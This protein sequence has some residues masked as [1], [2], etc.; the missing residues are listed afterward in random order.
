[1][2]NMLSKLLTNLNSPVFEDAAARAVPKA[3][4]GDRRWVPLSRW[5]P[6]GWRGQAEETAGER[7][8]PLCM[9]NDLARS[10]VTC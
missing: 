2:A 5:P 7:R 6:V 9:S 8:G 3:M 1:M 10:S 4:L